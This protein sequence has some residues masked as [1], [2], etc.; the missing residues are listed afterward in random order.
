MLTLEKIKQR[1]QAINVQAV[2][3]AAGVHP[4][5]VYGIL[6]G[7]SPNYETVKKLSDYFEAVEK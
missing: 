1:L 7:R 5:T 2:S 3:R 4:N 6:A